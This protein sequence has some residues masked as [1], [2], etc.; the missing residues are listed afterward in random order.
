MLK[1]IEVKKLGLK[2]LFKT[3][4]YLTIIP[5]TILFLIGLFLTVVGAIV[6]EWALLGL[7]IAYLFIPAIM[8]L[9]YAGFGTLIGLLYN[10]LA[11]KFGGLELYIAED[12]G[13][14]LSVKNPQPQVDQQQVDQQ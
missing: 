12:N 14:A 3:I 10:G 8:I 1:K 4:I 6:G 11:G 2:S 9:I 13:Q 5:M 7:G